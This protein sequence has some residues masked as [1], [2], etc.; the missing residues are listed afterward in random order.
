MPFQELS[1]RQSIPTVL[2]LSQPQSLHSLQHQATFEFTRHCPIQF[3]D[4]LQF[5]VDMVVI[6]SD[7]AEDTIG[8]ASHVLGG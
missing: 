7:G 5:L 3:L 2:P 8:M 4:S 6:G 1:Q